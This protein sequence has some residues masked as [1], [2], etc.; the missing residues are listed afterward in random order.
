MNDRQNNLLAASQL[1][2]LY[3]GYENLLENRA[4]SEANDVNAANNKQ[5][6]LLLREINDRFAEQNLILEDLSYKLNLVLD[7]LLNS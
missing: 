3:L 2:S 6:D 7:I 5:A 4:Q 1:L